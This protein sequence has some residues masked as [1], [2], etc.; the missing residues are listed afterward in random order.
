MRFYRS[1]NNPVLNCGYMTVKSVQVTTVPFEPL[2]FLVQFR[3]A[4]QS[5]LSRKEKPR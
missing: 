1:V 3:I 4:R 5:K 2:G